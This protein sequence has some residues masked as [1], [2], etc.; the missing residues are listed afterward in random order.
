MQL[1]ISHEEGYVLGVVH[2]A[3][4]DSAGGLFREYL[5]PLLEVHG[6]KIVLDLSD[7]HR[8]NSVGIGHLVNLVARA[9]TQSN[10]IVLASV[11]PLLQGVFHVTRL[12]KFLAIADNLGE[13]LARLSSPDLSGGYDFRSLKR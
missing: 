9:N 5:S 12:D 6:T 11:S 1:H 8:I 13:A 2:G 3:I 4:D 10:R 7:C